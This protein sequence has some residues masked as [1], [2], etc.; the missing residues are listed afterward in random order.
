MQF[1]PMAVDAGASIF[2]ALRG[3][4]RNKRDISAAGGPFD[5]LAGI[6]R[7]EWDTYNRHSSPLL[8]DLS[9][10]VDDPAATSRRVAQAGSD[11]D[12]A[13]GLERERLDMQLSRHG[14]DPSSGRYAGTRRSLSLAQAADKAAA[15]SGERARS[16]DMAFGRRMG[17]LRALQGNRSAAMRAAAGAGV[18]LSRLAGLRMTNRNMRDSAVTGAIGNLAGGVYQKVWGDEGGDGA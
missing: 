11:V 6:G 4:R 7:A 13:Y 3:S 5:Q 15:M 10:D 1:I 14:I 18:G 17:L 12:N 8:E 2:S 16:T 9:R